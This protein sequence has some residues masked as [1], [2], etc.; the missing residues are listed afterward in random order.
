MT[1]LSRDAVGFG[2]PPLLDQFDFSS[3]FQSKMSRLWWEA[4]VK[5]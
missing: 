3:A 1:A 5:V 4:I 2:Y